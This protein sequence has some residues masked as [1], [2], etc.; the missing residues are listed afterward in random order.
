MLA[1]FLVTVVPASSVAQTAEP[2]IGTGPGDVAGLLSVDVPPGAAPAGTTVT[3]EP[4]DPD[5]RP[6]EL[7]DLPMR[8]PFHELLPVDARFSAPVTVTRSI[9]FGALEEGVYDPAT[10][11]LIVSAL[12][13]RDTDG[14]WSWLADAQV[15]LDPEGGAF[16][17]TG[18]TD[19]GGPIIGYRAGDLV[20]ATEDASATPVGEVFRVEGQLRVDPGSLAEI[21]DVTGRTSDESIA[22]PVRSY[23]VEFF[24]RARGLE[25]ECL[26][27]GT[28]QYEATFAIGDVADVGPLRSAIGLTGTDV[29][30]V[31]AGE[32]TCE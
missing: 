5:V 6:D 2:S 26:A 29:A 1:L 15:R 24:D 13:T 27:P 30:I 17:V 11:G 14:T 16:L 10:D 31:H 12:F 20:V 3:V 18:T 9:P 19:H 7:R 32:H 21:A 4:R 28:V 22:K 25:L 23:E 8:H